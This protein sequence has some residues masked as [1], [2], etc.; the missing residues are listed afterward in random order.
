MILSTHGGGGDSSGRLVSRQKSNSSPVYSQQPMANESQTNVAVS[1]ILQRPVTPSYKR[2]QPQ[3]ST[4]LNINNKHHHQ[5]DSL[6]TSSSFVSTSASFHQQKRQQNGGSHVDVLSIDRGKT[7]PS[8]Q[9]QLRRST[10][11]AQTPTSSPR[12]SS[13]VSLF[14]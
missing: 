4:P 9:Q 14:K 3:P 7:P 8:P 13:R 2:Q 11:R 12:P 6:L 10:S 5:P 1:G